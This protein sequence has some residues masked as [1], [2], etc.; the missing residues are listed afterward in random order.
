VLAA[1]AFLSVP[2]VHRLERR[3]PFVVAMSVVAVG[4][5]LREALMGRG[6]GPDL[7]MPYSVGW[8]FALGWAAAVATR[9]WHRLAVS[10]AAL[11]AMP[12]YFYDL[13]R[14]AVVV[15]GLLLLVWAPTIPTTP[16]LRRMLG[17][18]AASS[19][20]VYVTHWQVY[21]HLQDGAP[22]LA[23]LASLAVGI[24]Y[25]QVCARAPGLV[26]SLQARR[27]PA[28]HAAQPTAPSTGSRGR[29]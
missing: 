12:G 18:L 16:V 11:A 26:A 4:L 22:A 3:A 7:E 1:V 28:G 10:A 19:L 24:G 6:L 5:L 17:V 14:E 9:T 27:A 2:A 25:W 15:G 8:L 13:P 29:A 20:Y 23:L 21:P